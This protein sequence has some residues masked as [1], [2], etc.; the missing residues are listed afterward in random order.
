MGIDVMRLKELRITKGYSQERLAKTLNVSRSTV[1]MWETR[2][3]SIDDDMLIRLADLLGCSTDYLLGRDTQIR[4]DSVA[5]ARQ[6][7]LDDPDRR[8]LLNLA[9]HGTPEAVRQI[10]AVIDALRA[11]NPDFYDGDDPA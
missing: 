9:R 11:T 4:P 2:K 5:Q 7:L 10:A 1:A 8:A 6:E 3:N